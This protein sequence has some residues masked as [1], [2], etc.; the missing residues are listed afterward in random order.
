MNQLN[1]KK[2]FW[3][4]I[5]KLLTK[6]LKKQPVPVFL[7]TQE[8]AKPEHISYETWEEYNEMQKYANLDLVESRVLLKGPCD[9]FGYSE[10]YGGVYV[11]QTNGRSWKLAIPIK[12]FDKYMQAVYGAEI[13]SKIG[14]KRYDTINCK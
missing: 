13:V 8:I 9:V 1:S 14:D 5:K 12:Q 3:F 4:T 10:F 11:E 6:S 7:A 2:G